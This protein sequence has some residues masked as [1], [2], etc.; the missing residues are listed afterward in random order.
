MEFV[1]GFLGMIFYERVSM[2]VSGWAWTKRNI[3]NML[4]PCH[5]KDFV[6]DIYDGEIYSL[7]QRYILPHYQKCHIARFHSMAPMGIWQMP[8]RQGFWNKDISNHVAICGLEKTQNRHMAIIGAKTC[9]AQNMD[10]SR[11]WKL[12]DPRQWPYKTW[13]GKLDFKTY[14]LAVLTFGAVLPL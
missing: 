11:S 10:N 14:F 9:I 7:T 6:I 3:S 1:E 13:E 5:P 12:I 2:N 8:C 4:H